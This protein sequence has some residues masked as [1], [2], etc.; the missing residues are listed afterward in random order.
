MWAAQ[1]RAPPRTRSALSSPET[2]VLRG[3]CWSR[4]VLVRHSLRPCAPRNSTLP[5]SISLVQLRDGGGRLFTLA[6]CGSVGKYWNIQWCGCTEKQAEIYCKGFY[7]LWYYYFSF[8][9]FLSILT[10]Q[11]NKV[12][13]VSG[14]FLKRLR[15]SYL[16][17]RQRLH[18]SSV[19]GH[20]QRSWSLCGRHTLR[21]RPGLLWSWLLGAWHP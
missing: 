18:W 15:S 2:S 20:V 14:L 12:P 16:G 19:P 5:A 17:V 6:N 7:I 8:H 4:C 1:L 3:T 10:V 13:L 21:L 11:V 9:S